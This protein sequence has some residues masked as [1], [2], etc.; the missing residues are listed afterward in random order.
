VVARAPRVGQVQRLTPALLGAAVRR[1]GIPVDIEWSGAPNVQVVSI[2]RQIAGKDVIDM[3]MAY[4]E[5]VDP[6]AGFTFNVARAVEAVD[7]PSGA[8]KLHVRG[9]DPAILAPRTVVWVDISVDGTL[10]RSVQVPVD[11]MLERMVLVARADLR[12]GETVRAAQFTAERRN[13]AGQ[14]KAMPDALPAIGQLRLARAVRAGEVL[15]AEKIMMAD[16][17]MAGDPVRVVARTHGMAVEM[18]GIVVRGGSSGQGV[19][20]RV[21]HSAQTIAGNLADGRTVF[22]Q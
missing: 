19:G 11:V 3:A 9:I 18:D 4:L 10:Y 2:A 16:G 22:V 1:A 15:T 21:A 12:A 14:G 13:V 5:T 20:V 7:V 17:V 8:A 6:H